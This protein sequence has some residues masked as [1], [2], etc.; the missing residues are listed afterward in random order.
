MNQLGKMKCF[1]ERNNEAT[2]EESKEGSMES[3]D[4]YDFW[5]SL[6]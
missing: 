4:Y 3:L 2:Q 5:I 6:D 1:S